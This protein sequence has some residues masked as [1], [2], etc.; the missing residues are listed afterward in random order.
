M[1]TETTAANE[2]PGDGR[3]TEKKQNPDGG[4]ISKMHSAV[5]KVRPGLAEEQ[6]TKHTNGAQEDNNK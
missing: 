2:T 1:H 6:N 5:K 4:N 3:T